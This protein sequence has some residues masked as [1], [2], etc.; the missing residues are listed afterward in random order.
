MNNSK[1]KSKMLGRKILFWRKW[2]PSRGKAK[3]RKSKNVRKKLK[4]SWKK[5]RRK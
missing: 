5:S 4:G 3:L 2:R 1:R